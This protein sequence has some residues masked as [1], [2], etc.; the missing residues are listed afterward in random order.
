MACSA[1]SSFHILAS[2]HFSNFLLTKLLGRRRLIQNC[3]LTWGDDMQ[4]YV[5]L[6]VEERKLAIS[7]D[8]GLITKY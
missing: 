8:R 1:K 2:A 7:V 4:A 6:A 5:K 3:C